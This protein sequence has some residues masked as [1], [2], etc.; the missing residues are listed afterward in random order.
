MAKREEE[1]EDQWRERDLNIGTIDVAGEKK[2]TQF[3]LVIEES[4]LKSQREDDGRKDK[5]DKSPKNTQKVCKFHLEGRC[6]YKEEC[7]NLHQDIKGGRQEH[8]RKSYSDKRTSGRK[9]E[10][11]EENHSRTKRMDKK[12]CNG[13]RD[14]EQNTHIERDDRKGRSR[15]KGNLS[16]RQVEQEKLDFLVKSMREMKKFMGPEHPRKEKRKGGRNQ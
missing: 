11:D 6:R 4:V 16:A 13:R 7:K 12:R 2:Q 14:Q 3:M 10:M 8:T 9:E 5:S 15:E 1:Q